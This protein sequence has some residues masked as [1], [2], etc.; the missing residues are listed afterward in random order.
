MGPVVVVVVV[1]LGSS[2]RRCRRCR[3]RS[4]FDSFPYLHLHHLP[5][6]LL[7]LRLLLQF[8]VDVVDQQLRRVTRGYDYGSMRGPSRHTLVAWRTTSSN[9]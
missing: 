1:V 3:C 4:R 7:V 2:S 9:P 6:L 5:F 8:V